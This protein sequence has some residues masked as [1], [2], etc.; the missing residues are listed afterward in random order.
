MVRRMAALEGDFPGEDEAVLGLD[1]WPAGHA[2]YLF[3]EAFLRDLSERGER[4][5]CPSWPGS[6]PGR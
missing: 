5:R 2:P 1:R 6:T 4:T 3:G